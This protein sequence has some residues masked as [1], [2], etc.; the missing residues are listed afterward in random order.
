MTDGLK[1][2]FAWCRNVTRRR[3]RNF[4]YSF[5][6]LRR[7]EHDA[8][9]AIY[10]FM[11]QCDD[12][13]DDSSDAAQGRSALER[14][15][16]DMEAALAGRAP[17]HPVWPAFAATVARYRM[18][19][20]GFR[21]MIAGVASDLEPVD[22]RTYEDLYRYC[23]RVASVAGLCVVHILGYESREALALAEKCGVAFQ[24]T[25]ILRD[26]K[27]DAARGRVYFPE[28]DLARFGVR[29]ED[30][31]RG[32]G[33]GEFAELMRFEAGRARALYAE[34]ATLPDLVPSRNRAC[35]RALIEIYRRL[36]DRIE[37]SN[38]DVLTRRI[39]LPAWEKSL[40][41]LRAWLAR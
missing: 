13:A 29:R 37:E 17:D 25:N 39:A 22:F 20:D 8:L 31:L 1:E 33:S 5:V 21:D 15:R 23:Y 24:L 14:W 6:L 2:S 32:N 4:Y 18:P 28:E 7:E 16:G 26:V 19:H 41:V 36:L 9:C 27:E 10:A 3:A 35:L 38:F 12:L 34:S 30:L 40:I 11:R